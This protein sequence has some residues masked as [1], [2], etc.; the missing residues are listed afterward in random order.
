MPFRS[1]SQRRYLWANEPDLAKK[2]AKKYGTPKKLPLH[3]P[4]KKK[5]VKGVRR[6]AAGYY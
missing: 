3:V 6:N 5:V 4:A 1:E 2:W